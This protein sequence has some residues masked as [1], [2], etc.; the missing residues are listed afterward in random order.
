VTGAL[1]ANL[2][3]RIAHPDVEK[4]IPSVLFFVSLANAIEKEIHRSSKK[5]NIADGR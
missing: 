5:P 1:S 3:E 4:P 2:L